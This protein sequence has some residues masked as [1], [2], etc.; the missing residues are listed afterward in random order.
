MDNFEESVDVEATEWKPVKP[1]IQRRPRSNPTEI[2]VKQEE[3]RKANLAKA[4]EAR[5]AKAK[6]AASEKVKPHDE[7]LE[8]IELL[9]ADINKARM[10]AYKVSEPKPL[11]VPHKQ[12]AYN[13][14]QSSVVN[15]VKRAL[16]EL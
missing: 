15:N 7:R 5:L 4:R 9:L 10:E 6:L 16:L 14:N 3:A 8:R 1:K 11:P 2:S 12:P 13:P